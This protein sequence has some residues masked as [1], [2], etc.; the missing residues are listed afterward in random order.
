M[1][2]LYIIFFEG[3]FV[4]PKQMWNSGSSAFWQIFSL[5]KSVPAKRKKGFYTSRLPKNEETEG[6]IVISGTEL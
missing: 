5:N 3:G 2:E 4:S 6:I 1:K